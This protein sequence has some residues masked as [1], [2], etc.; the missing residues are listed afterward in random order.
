[1]TAESQNW[2]YEKF[3]FNITP[4]RKNREILGDPAPGRRVEGE[5][6][7]ATVINYGVHELLFFFFL[8]PSSILLNF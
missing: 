2:R 1:M 4:Q 7:E 3:S 6:V 5:R 8:G